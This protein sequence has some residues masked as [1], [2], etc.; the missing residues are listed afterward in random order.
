MEAVECGAASLA[1][2]LAYYGRWV[3]LEEL[4]IKCGVSRDG[5]KASNILKAARTFGF[6]AK[7]YSKEPSALRNLSL[8]M[9]VFWN[10]NHFLVVEGFA[11]GK[12]YLNDPASGR[13]VV[14]NDE[15][16]QSFVGVVLTFEKNDDFKPGGKREGVI[17][18]LRRNFVGLNDAIT[19]LVLIGVAL[20]FPGLLVPV[21]TS[22]FIDHILIDHMSGWLQP[23]IIGMVITALLR[24]GL[25]WLE[26][27]YLL[28]VRVQLGLKLTSKFF[29]H[30]LRL[31][32]GFYTQR[33]PG[34]IS[35]RIAINDHVAEILTDDIIKAC[36][37]VFQILMF[38]ILM[39]FYSPLLTFLSILVISINLFLTHLVSQ[40]TQEAS[41]KLAI[42]RGKVYGA[43]ISGLHA[44]ETLKTSG[45]ESGFFSKWAGYQAKFVNSEQRAASVGLVL[46]TIP[47]LLSTFNNLLI[48][49]VGGLLVIDGHMSVGMLVAYQSL[50]M[51][52]SEPIKGLI[53]LS[54]KILEAKGSMNR[55]ED[56]MNYKVDPW[57]DR[58][59][60]SDNRTLSR[61]DGSVQLIDI[62]FGYSPAEKS[63]VTNFNLTIAP[64][65]HIAIVGPSGCGKST[66]SRLVMGLFEPWSGQILFDGKPREFYNRYEFYNSVT[67]IDQDAFLF[68]GTIKDNISMWDTTISEKEIM[69]AAKDACIHEDIVS[70]PGG[71]YSL[72]DEGGSNFSGGQR[73]RIE[74]ARAL[75]KN[76]RILLMDEGTSALDPTTEAIFIN[77]LKRR[78]CTCITVAHRLSSIREADNIVVLN[79]GIIIEQGTHEVLMQIENGFYQSLVKQH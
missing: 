34:E 32:I 52:F 46:G 72:V 54:K 78:G 45:G 6:T 55:L 8:P 5:S 62:T 48:L 57:L 53:E 69:L 41:M 51:S 56:V 35:S 68:E 30:A 22:T 21:F 39:L 67:L 20:V 63:L 28:R 2:I 37:S 71:Y 61:L 77:N 64:G 16:D 14:S 3:S 7:G 79:A 13:R 50:S 17:S 49:A 75:V 73:Q 29:W 36:L 70:R 66:I 76:P 10:F 40:K 19:Y 59:Q 58:T 23:L 47:E 42:D 9:I 11:D 44:M 15:F 24:T 38:G 25:T 27:Y 74:I 12:V 65:E 33:S 31:P 4:R 60:E 43:T 1:M 26:K 18:V